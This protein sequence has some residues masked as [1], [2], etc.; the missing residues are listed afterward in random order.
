MPYNF[1]SK[2]HGSSNS[3]IK[4][5]VNIHQCKIFANLGKK[6]EYSFFLAIRRSDSKN[7]YPLIVDAEYIYLY[8]FFFDEL[9]LHEKALKPSNGLHKWQI[10]KSE[11]CQRRVKREES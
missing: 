4:K 3:A 1:P 6:T 5:H 7:A 10:Y 8:S 9:A 2:A 11:L